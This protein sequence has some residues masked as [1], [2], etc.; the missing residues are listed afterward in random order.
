MSENEAVEI[1]ENSEL[2]SLIAEEQANAPAAST[3]YD[4]AQGDQEDADAAKASADADASATGSALIGTLVLESLIQTVWPQVAINT[5]QKEVFAEKLKA[6]M[7]KYGGGG[8]PPWL[9][10]YKEEL[11]LCMFMSITG[12][13]IYQQVQMAKEKEVNGEESQSQTA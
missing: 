13:G 2:E 10:V 7:L 5:E 8:L 3:D 6:V 1:P 9:A 12:F 11:E 4:P